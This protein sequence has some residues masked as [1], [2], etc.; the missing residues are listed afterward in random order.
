MEV[1][2]MFGGFLKLK[3]LI[4]ILMKHQDSIILKKINEFMDLNKY[5]LL[6]LKIYSSSI[7]NKLKLKWKILI[8]FWIQDIVLFFQMKNSLIQTKMLKKTLVEL[9]VHFFQEDKISYLINLTI[10]N[11]VIIIQ[12]NNL[13]LRV[14][15]R[16]IFILLIVN[17]KIH[18]IINISKGFLNYPVIKVSFSLED[19]VL[20]KILKKK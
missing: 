15:M 4:E 9:T 3:W 8:I 6:L 13:T 2:V 17:L 14:T 5:L 19:N 11:M 7:K 1:V 12:L 20:M 16:I 10:N 18:K